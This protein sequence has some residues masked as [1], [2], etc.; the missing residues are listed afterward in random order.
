MK[1]V[2]EHTFQGLSLTE[3]ETLFFDE[4]FNV[5]LG[6]SLKLGR[7]LVRLDRTADRIVR[8]LRCEPKREPGSA[9]AKLFG[10]KRAGWSEE[11][12]Y[13][14]GKFHGRWTTIPSLMTDKITT[15][16]T[17]EFAPA[18]SGVR[19]IVKGEVTVDVFG[20]GR[21]IEKAIVAG[22]EKGYV[23][24]ADFTATWVRQMCARRSA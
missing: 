3:F 21:Q 15:N 22:I 24:G 16:G 1:Y 20:V 9:G 14:V 4:E 11:L 23:A 5:A 8:H 12:E 13:D 18:P 17:I 6:E 2:I 7:T 19:R 10:D